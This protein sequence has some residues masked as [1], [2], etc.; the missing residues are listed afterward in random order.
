MKNKRFSGWLSS[1]KGLGR[2]LAIA[3]I[4]GVAVSGIGVTPASAAQTPIITPG[5]SAFIT[6]PTMTTTETVRAQRDGPAYQTVTASTEVTHRMRNG[7]VNGVQAYLYACLDTTTITTSV[8][9][10]GSLTTAAIDAKLDDV[11]ARQ[12]ADDIRNSNFTSSY[13]ASTNRTTIVQQY[14]GQCNNNVDVV[15]GNGR[16]LWG[17]ATSRAMVAYVAEAI[18]STVVAVAILVLFQSYAPAYMAA[19]PNRINA[20]A[21]CV[22]GIAGAVLIGL[23]TGVTNPTSMASWAALGCVATMIIGVSSSAM[24]QYRSGFSRLAVQATAENGVELS[25]IRSGSVGASSYGTTTTSVDATFD[26][27]GSALQSSIGL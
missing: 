2:P 24:E 3:V 6:H 11:A 9:T 12:V 1:V 17:T 14:S 13:N 22:G 23:I 26:A 15:D 8:V 19:Y 18:V 25:S 20:F 5:Y 7:F 10:R 27:L 16:A 4:V 21:F